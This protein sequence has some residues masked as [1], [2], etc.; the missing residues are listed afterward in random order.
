MK[1][2]SLAAVVLAILTLAML[3][4]FAQQESPKFEVY[5]NEHFGIWFKYMPGFTI[6]DKSTNQDMILNLKFKDLGEVYSL[7][8]IPNLGAD[9]KES[10]QAIYDFIKKNDEVNTKLSNYK[11][12]ELIDTKVGYTFME[13]FTV[14]GTWYQNLMM[15]K[16]LPTANSQGVM[17]R[18]QYEKQYANSV[19]S[20][21]TMLLAT[22]HKL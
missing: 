21:A 7:K 13:I 19:S 18:V 22:V 4:S 12:S 8:T 5:K 2:K 11:M 1:N 10:A 17:L 15:I 20:A 6:E 16:D 9:L 3:K 14:D